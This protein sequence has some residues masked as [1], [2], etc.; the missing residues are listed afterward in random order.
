MYELSLVTHPFQPFWCQYGEARTRLRRAVRHTLR[1]LIEQA[2]GYA[3]VERP[4]LEL[5][6][7]L[8]NNNEADL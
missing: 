7:C 8:R 5:H 1:R 2:G 6:D 4:I 3:D